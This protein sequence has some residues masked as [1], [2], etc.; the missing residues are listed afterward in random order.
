MAYE[1]PPGKFPPFEHPQ[2]LPEGD[3]R[4]ATLVSISGWTLEARCTAPQCAHRG[5]TY[6]P[7]RRAAADHGWNTLL[8]DYI[9]RIKC[10][11]CGSRFK[12]V[13]LVDDPR[14]LAPLVPMEAA[15]VVV[16]EVEGS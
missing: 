3:I 13:R 15:R 12:T 11:E 8:G 6:M 5:G 14:A 4:E 9:R 10:K 1:R 16:V 7:L 2:E